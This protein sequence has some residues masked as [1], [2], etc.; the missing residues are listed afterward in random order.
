M[1]SRKVQLSGG[2][3][4]TVSL[5]KYWATEHGIKAGSVLALHPKSDGSLLVD[6]RKDGE[7]VDRSTE[8]SFSTDN[9]SEIRQRIRAAYMVGVDSLVLVD[10]SGHPDD[11]RQLVERA[12]A[13][14][15]GFEVL[16][17]TTTRTRL[18]NLVEADNVNV[19]KTTLRLRLMTLAMHRDAVT[20]VVD[21][22]AELARQVVERD[23]EVDKLFAMVMR[24]FRRSLMDLTEVEKLGCSR[25]ELFEYYYTA[26][27]LE[28]VADHAV[29]I[30]RF[31]FDPEAF[32]PEGYASTLSDLG[33]VARGVVD[34]ATDVIL[35]EAGISAANDAL[36]DRDCVIKRIDDLDRDL[37]ECDDPGEAYVLGLLLD[38]LRRTAEY[39]ANAAEAGLQQFTRETVER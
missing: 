3:T 36:A 18:Q 22:D 10:R 23:A 9:E 20:A 16:E 25:D 38:S 31:T 33:K 1:E 29:K 28:R 14:L 21:G 19:R 26:R 11:R 30:A 32:F 6:A 27:Q 7:T 12:L 37:Y 17:T 5:P 13:G 8:V 39:G 35:T 34:D 2:T 15:P 24:Y 4:Y